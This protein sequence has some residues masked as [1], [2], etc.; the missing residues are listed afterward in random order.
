MNFGIL[1]WLGGQ[2]HEV[3]VLLVGDRLPGPVMRYRVA[4]VAGPRVRAARTFVFGLSIRAVARGLGVR[5]RGREGEAMLGASTS[6]HDAAWCK[7]WLAAWRPD[8]VF[9]DTI[10]RAPV[11]DAARRGIL[12]AHDV[13]CERAASLAAAGLRVRPEV[14]RAA[15]AGWLG[16]ADYVA[17]ISPEDAA[18]FK[19]M[20]AARVFELPM[21]ASPCPAPAGAL[22]IPGRLVFVGSDA[23]HNLDGMRWFLGDV[24]PRLAGVTLDIVGDCG[25]ALGALP[26]GVVARG[27]HGELRPFLHRAALAIS[28]LR[29]GSGLKIKMLDYARH[30]VWTVAT[31]VSLAGFP[32]DGAPFWAAGDAEGFAAAVRAGLSAAP[33][34]PAA[35]AY[36][37]RHFGAEVCFAPLAAVLGDIK[38]P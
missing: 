2:G 7:R 34:E 30:G 32:P 1:S 19:E 28:P 14:T 9:V 33:D 31:T 8:A 29:A 15:E 24:W 4:H 5:R 21:P 36:V 3:V 13:V 6:A 12:V 10:F 37:A 22:R 23:P 26:E 38:P 25:A 27:R 16:Q 17:A 20:G 11:L 35:L 18:A